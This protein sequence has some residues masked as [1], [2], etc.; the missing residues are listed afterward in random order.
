MKYFIQVGSEIKGS[1]TIEELREFNIT[2]DTKV[3]PD[4]QG[5]F[6]DEQPYTKAEKFEELAQLFSKPEPNIPLPIILSEI[7][8]KTYDIKSAQDVSIGAEEI[9]KITPIP[10]IETEGNNPP[11]K[12]KIIVGISLVI[13]LAC[14]WWTN[15]L[16]GSEVIGSTIDTSSQK[17][18][19]ETP[20]IINCE[21][22]FDSLLKSGE[23]NIEQANGESLTAFGLMKD[24]K[25]CADK[26]KVKTLKAKFNSQITTDEAI[27][28]DPD[29][30]KRNTQFK[31]AIKL[32][33][34]II[35]PNQ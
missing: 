20:K 10:P 5:D 26:E 34:E 2:R 13:L 3:C 12:V 28:N 17:L 15:S 30:Q 33:D 23:E 19:E 9:I 14:Y 1:F 25:D 32:L 16:R 4:G 7:D 18:V 6:T 29:I 31:E 11:P 27:I 21:A 8:E 24:Y 22:K 35:I